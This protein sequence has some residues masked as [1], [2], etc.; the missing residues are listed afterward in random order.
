MQ[1]QP[2]FKP[3]HFCIK[4]NDLL[5]STRSFEA[6]GFIVTQG[7]DTGGGSGNCFVILQEKVCI[8]IVR[9]GPGVILKP[10]SA[11]LKVTGLMNLMFSGHKKFIRRLLVHWV[12]ARTGGYMD[13]CF[14]ANPL[15]QA[16]ADARARGVD[17][18]PEPFTH[19]RQKGDGTKTTWRLAGGLD[20]SLPF[21]IEEIEESAERIPIRLDA[22][23][24]NGASKLDEVVIGTPDPAATIKGLEML[25]GEKGEG[26]TIKIG[27]TNFRAEHDP[28]FKTPLP[29]ELIFTSDNP[30]AEEKRL[31]PKLTGG[32]Q[33]TI[34]KGSAAP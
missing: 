29:K 6:A 5:T 16:I 18:T 30:S 17:V 24:P 21:L 11:F 23:H 28:S 25:T 33:I 20:T 34:R 12:R 10:M 7:S 32:A 15:E 14:A 1:N 2:T 3:D 9:Q 27:Y 26:N 13:W 31:D 4:S 19:G 8:E 22:R